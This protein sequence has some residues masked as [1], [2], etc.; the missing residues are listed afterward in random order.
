MGGFMGTGGYFY[1]PRGIIF[2]HPGDEKI[3]SAREEQ[4]RAR[5]NHEH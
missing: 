3:A 1:H 5:I 4:G 2:G